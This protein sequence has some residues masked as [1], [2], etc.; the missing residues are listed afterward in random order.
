MPNKPY[1]LAYEAR[2]K[3]V[4]EAGFERWGHSPDDEE[5][6][7]YLTEWVNKYNLQGKR[8]IEFACGEGASGEILSIA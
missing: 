4:Y 7:A 2:Y 5:L 6:I 1:Y 3:K 8:I